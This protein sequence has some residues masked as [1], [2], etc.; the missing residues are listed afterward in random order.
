MYYEI[1]QWFVNYNIDIDIGLLLPDYTNG[2]QI[3]SY[4]VV[5]KQPA[6]WC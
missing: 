4:N 6:A 1:T 2:F 3:I 5:F